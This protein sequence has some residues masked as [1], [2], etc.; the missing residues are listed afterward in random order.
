MVNYFLYHHPSSRPLDT[1]STL[2]VL[3]RVSAGARCRSQ[4][5]VLVRKMMRERRNEDRPA[6][7][8]SK[9]N[10]KPKKSIDRVAGAGPRS[11]AS[12]RN[13][14]RA[15]VRDCGEPARDEAQA[16]TAP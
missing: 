7:G 14:R 8:F 12:E 3:A 1:R 10:P 13:W 11:N 4:G 9:K 5:V 2:P 15:G 16:T 6:V